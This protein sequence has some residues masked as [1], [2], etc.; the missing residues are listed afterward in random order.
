MTYTVM[1]SIVVACIG[2]K[3]IGMAYMVMGYV[4]GMAFY[5][6]RPWHTYTVMA[7]IV[8]AHIVMAYIV[9]PT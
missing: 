9:R 2:T 6:R 4:A 8:M 7:Y 3:S 5:D 1:A